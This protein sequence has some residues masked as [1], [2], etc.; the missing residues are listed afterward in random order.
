MD[1]ASCL[2]KLL[3]TGVF[4]WMC[5]RLQFQLNSNQNKNT[6]SIY[7]NFWVCWKFEKRN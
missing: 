2:R 3:P 7:E 4:G 1:G 6:R 5:K